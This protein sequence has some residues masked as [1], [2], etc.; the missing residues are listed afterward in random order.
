[1]RRLLRRHGGKETTQSSYYWLA[2]SINNKRYII[3]IPYRSADEANEQ[4]YIHMQGATNMAVVPLRTMSKEQAAKMLNAEII[5]G[6]RGENIIM[7]SSKK[8]FGFWSM[9]DRKSTRLNSSHH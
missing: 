9:G 8:G 5:E 1:M 4:G 3:G 2:L 6:K 7:P